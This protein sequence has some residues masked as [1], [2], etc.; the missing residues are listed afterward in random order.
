MTPETK[1][2]EPCTRLLAAQNDEAAT[3]ILVELRNVLHEYCEIFRRGRG[4]RKLVVKKGFAA[5]VANL[6]V[7]TR[8]FLLFGWSGSIPFEPL[9]VRFQVAPS[10]GVPV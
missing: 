4:L 7:S 3:S 2:S 5:R 10:L 9:R 6:L 1:I 8:A